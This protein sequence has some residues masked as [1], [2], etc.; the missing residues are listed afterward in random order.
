MLLFLSNLRIHSL[1]KIH[2]VIY[3]KT[4][5][6]HKMKQ[7]YDCIVIIFY[8]YR[9]KFPKEW[10]NHSYETCPKV[11]KKPCIMRKEKKI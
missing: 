1:R 8:S 10:W 2:H 3:E 4:H 6:I 11:S 9:E 7:K 5:E